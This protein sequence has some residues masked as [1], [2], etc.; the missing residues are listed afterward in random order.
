MS[1]LLILPFVGL[2]VLIG[3]CGFCMA[4]L[5]PVSRVPRIIPP[6]S[7]QSG[8]V[9]DNPLLNRPL[10]PALDIVYNKSGIPEPRLDIRF[11]GCTCGSSFAECMKKRCRQQRQELYERGEITG[12]EAYPEHVFVQQ[13]RPALLT[14][15]CEVRYE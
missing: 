15:E 12:Q 9:S 10:N 8:T 1:V 3:I 13:D 11:I 14:M 2:L 4:C 5:P 6:P 7:W